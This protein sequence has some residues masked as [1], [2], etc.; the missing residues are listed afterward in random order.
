M[1]IRSVDKKGFPCL[2]K[3]IQ[4]VQATKSRVLGLHVLVRVPESRSAGSKDKAITRHVAV[5][6]CHGWISFHKV[7][8][9]FSS[10]PQTVK[11]RTICGDINFVII[12]NAERFC[13]VDEGRKEGRKCFI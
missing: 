13:I 4:P 2:G 12:L 5:P 1:S 10:D 8:N 7:I 3:H 9:Y 6:L 11:L